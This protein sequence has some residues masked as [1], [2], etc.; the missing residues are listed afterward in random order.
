MGCNPK[1]VPLGFSSMCLIIIAELTIRAAFLTMVLPN[2]HLLY[3]Y[4]FT[5]ISRISWDKLE[6]R[7]GSQNCVHHKHQQAV[8]LSAVVGAF[9]SVC[10]CS[11]NI[12]LS[13]WALGMMDQRACIYIYIYNV[14]VCFCLIHSSS[15]VW[16]LGCHQ[17]MFHYKQPSLLKVSANCLWVNT[18][19][20]TTCMS[21]AC[22][23]SYGLL[24]LPHNAPVIFIWTPLCL[25]LQHQPICCT[26]WAVVH[27]RPQYPHFESCDR[28]CAILVFLDWSTSV[29]IF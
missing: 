16:E 8:C 28:K 7:T 3:L 29:Q 21:C 19:M 25:H 18:R 17:S 10:T 20:A 2:R 27:S 22:R 11:C 5:G 6:L 14:C 26:L 24:S 13:S 4:A 1:C 12:H 15:N 9:S 23:I